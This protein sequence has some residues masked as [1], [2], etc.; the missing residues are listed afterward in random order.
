MSID[1]TFR[2]GS[3]WSTDSLLDSLQRSI[4]GTMRRQIITDLLEKGE[5]FPVIQQLLNEQLP[6]DLKSAWGKL[7]PTFMGGEYLPSRNQG[8]VEIA[9]LDLQS[10]TADVISIRARPTRTRIYYSI[11]DEYESDIRCRPFWSKQPLTLR[12]LIGLI[13]HIN[14]H[15]AE[16]TAGYSFII[17]LLEHQLR[18]DLDPE[19]LRHFVRVSSENYPQLQSWY[20]DVISR[21]IHS[22]KSEVMS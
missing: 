20:E 5:V 14:L 11:V 15:N 6:A 7:H 22:K 4:S 2:P 3:Y 1:L 21:W 18:D 16:P 12:Q 10:T 9:R 17:D 19:T 8:E 13:D